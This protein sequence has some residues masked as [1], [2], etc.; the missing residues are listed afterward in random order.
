MAIKDKY[1]KLSVIER[2]EYSTYMKLTHCQSQQQHDDFKV[3]LDHVDRVV[4]HK[5]QEKKRNLIKKFEKLC[6]KA[7]QK[8][9]SASFKT[10]EP[11]ENFVKNLSNVEFSD[12][13]LQLLNKGFKFA[14]QQN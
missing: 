1:S 5:Y 7:E 11:V 14:L 2:A 9:K 8:S 4:A 3:F 12:K 10:I 13:E 6:E